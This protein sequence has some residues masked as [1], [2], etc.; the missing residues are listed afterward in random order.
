MQ[1]PLF[2]T[3]LPSIRNRNLAEAVPDADAEL[4]K[5][6]AGVEERS[7]SPSPPLASNNPTSRGYALSVK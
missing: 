4:H 5:S 1:L 2:R 3:V 7:I 6:E